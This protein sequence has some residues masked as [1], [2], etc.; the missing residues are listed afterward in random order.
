[1]LLLS[2]YPLLL[3][4]LIV[5]GAI[6]GAHLR[7]DA[8]LRVIFRHIGMIVRQNIPLSAGLFCA[9]LSERGKTRR[10]LSRLSLLLETGV[11]L[12]DALELGYAACPIG[13]ESSV[14][15]AEAAG[16]LPDALAD[17]NGRLSDDRDEPGA[18]EAY[19]WHYLSMVI[20][21]F[22]IV[23][24][25]YQHFT[26]PKMVEITLDF[27]GSMSTEAAELVH[28]LPLFT[29]FPTGPVAR[30]YAVVFCAAI[31]Y[32]LLF[33][34]AWPLLRL[35][36]RSRRVGPLGELVESI[37]WH[38]WPLSGM[39]RLRCVVHSLPALRFALAA[40]RD[41][42]DAAAL[43]ADVRTNIQWQRRLI[44]WS[45]SQRAGHDA[46]A[47]ARSAGLPELLCRYIAAGVRD[48][49]FDAPL[50]SAE[51]YY[52]VLSQQRSRVFHTV[53]WPIGLLVVAA[54]VGLFSWGLISMINDII[55]Q[56]LQHV[57]VSQ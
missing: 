3:F 42:P 48:G 52:A 4:F 6:H 22:C 29:A 39:E 7:R 32:L 34:I 40:G 35:R 38:V 10:I 55:V 5:L 1:M 41:L 53:L 23:V 51:Q 18:D 16:T 21:F 45:A 47:S 57:E 20:V 36:R 24:S 33:N 13:I 9:A 11:P 31:A 50:Y 49:D 26:A 44:E 15:A 46:V 17:L 56:V 27:E 2:I 54:M 30:L 28:Y 8:R 37:R 19:R 14:R 43:A 25:A 12:S